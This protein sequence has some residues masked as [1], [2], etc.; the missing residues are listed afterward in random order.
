VATP[1]RL[2]SGSDLIPFEQWEPPVVGEPAAAHGRRDD[3]PARPMTASQ[4]EALQAQ[5]YREGLEQ[6]RR[7]GW[8]QGHSEGR[9][10]GEAAVQDLC[11]RL[12][13]IL[14]ALASPLESFDAEVEES[15]VALA[16]GLAR[17][18]VRRELKTDPGQVIAVVR[19]ALSMLPVASRGVRL[20]LHP[21]DAAL[22]RDRLRLAETPESAWQIA[23]DPTL[24]RG[25]CRVETDASQ[26]DA[27]VEHRLAAVVARVLGE[28][29]DGERAA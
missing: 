28:E 15:L 17:H 9:A 7:D 18:L 12:E 26:V 6:G 19:E 8:T 2:I 14:Q 5:A 22:V 11:Q 4:L 21:G 16:V 20:V 23:E 3:A 27:T 13:A 25:G 24:T 29:R 10:A 1:S